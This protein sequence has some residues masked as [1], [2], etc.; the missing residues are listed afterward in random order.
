MI[1]FSKPLGVLILACFLAVG[2][3]DGSDRKPEPKPK[4]VE[5]KKVDPKDMKVKTPTPGP[6]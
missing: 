2:C 5:G 3:D 6:D 1:P 4:P